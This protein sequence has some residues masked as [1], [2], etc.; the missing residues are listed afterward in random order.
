MIGKLI[1][2]RAKKDTDCLNFSFFD[3]SLTNASVSVWSSA[4]KAYATK[5]KG[6]CVNL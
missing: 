2:E 3:R 6:T 5:E 1:L 4:R